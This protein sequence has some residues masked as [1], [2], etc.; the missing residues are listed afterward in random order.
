MSELK[1]LSWQIQQTTEP[2]PFE[3]LERRGVRRRRR[4]QLLA[5]TGV[6]AAVA[7]AVLAALLPLGDLTGTGQPPP[8]TTPKPIVVDQAA[9]D[10][11]RGS[12]ALR[13]EVAFATATRWA[14]TWSSTYAG[15]PAYTAVLS[16]DSVRTT[17]PVRELQ[18]SVLR[19]R[20]ETIALSGPSGDE[21]SKDDPSWPRT[22]MV[23][24][25]DQGRTE[26]PLRWAAPT[27]TFAAN[28]IVTTAVAP[29][30]FPLILN[31]DDGTLRELRI[32]NAELLWSLVQD[33]TGRCWLVAMS[34][35]ASYV[36]WTDN[37]GSSWTKALLVSQNTTAGVWV[38]A[39]GNTVVAQSV[40]S[41]ESGGATPLRR[42]TD[43]GRTWTTVG[44]MDRSLTRGPAVFDDGRVLLLEPRSGTVSKLVLP[45]GEV[46]GEAP[47]DLNDLQ[48]G[49]GLLYGIINPSPEG[50]NAIL[51]STDDGK[52]WKRFEPR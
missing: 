23:R 22:V 40:S 13:G 18:Y 30:Q 14:A 33:S 25:T 16:R 29:K 46:V 44:A 27:T 31:P 43:R 28:E 9:E 51:T 1:E 38:S 8:A 52:T 24:L 17:A 12:D 37:G 41:E 4:R 3:A 15:K 32:P 21:F 48:G 39:D 35:S 42:S 2:L 10:L 34:G 11:L 47:R 7:I 5:G 19:T 20:D 45:G 50:T 26:K 49:D 36:F 6:V